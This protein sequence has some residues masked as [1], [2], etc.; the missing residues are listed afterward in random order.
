[1]LIMHIYLFQ[2]P[3]THAKTAIHLKK[4]KTWTIESDLLY[5]VP[6][7]KVKKLLTLKHFA[8]QFFL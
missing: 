5:K 7:L 2:V 3:N 8:V 4:K 1:M 6:K